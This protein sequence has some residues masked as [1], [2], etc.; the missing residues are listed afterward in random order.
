MGSWR[1]GILNPLGSICLTRGS[2]RPR[3]HGCIRISGTLYHWCRRF[4]PLNING[5]KE[6]VALKR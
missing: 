1:L 6:N 3:H 5:G 2:D 4:Q